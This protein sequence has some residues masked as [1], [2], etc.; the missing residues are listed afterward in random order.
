MQLSFYS[1]TARQQ[2]T[3]IQ[4]RNLR[5]NERLPSLA[6]KNL[7]TSTLLLIL[8]ISLLAATAVSQSRP[9]QVSQEHPSDLVRPRRVR[10]AS[11]ARPI[12]EQDAAEQVDRV[13]HRLD[14][15]IQDY[16]QPLKIQVA[17]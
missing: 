12:T 2:S 10:P 17:K 14:Q 8:T 6:M 9:R 4:T 5:K 11:K 1:A 16:L 7:L 13:L 3:I 15:L